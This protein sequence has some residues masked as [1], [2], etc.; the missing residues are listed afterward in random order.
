M[1]K[2]GFLPALLTLPVLIVIAIIAVILFGGVAFLTWVLAK[3]IFSLIGAALIVFLG[4]G[5]M[6]GMKAP[7]WLWII[8]VGL[9]AIPMV[10]SG[11]QQAT[12]AAVLG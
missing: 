6:K 2:K 5:F 7:Y 10:F 11:L 9:I 4:I 8:A 12:L 3:N 1:N